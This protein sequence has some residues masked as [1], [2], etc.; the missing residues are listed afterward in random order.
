MSKRGATSDC[1]AREF[2]NL[3]G[4]FSP[5]F[6]LYDIYIYI[7]VIYIY[8]YTYIYTVS[9]CHMWLSM[10]SLNGYRGH[11]Q[12]RTRPLQ[13]KLVYEFLFESQHVVWGFLMF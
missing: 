13:L 7:Y 6:L 11:F 3:F 2:N 1:E 4:L 10:I 12:V 9:I 5:L 8:I